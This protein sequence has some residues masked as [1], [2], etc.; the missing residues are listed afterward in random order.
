[1]ACIILHNM[2]LDDER[3]IYQNYKDTTKFEHDNT[4]YIAESSSQPRN[5]TYQVRADRYNNLTLKQYMHRR[6]E[7]WDRQVHNAL[8]RDLVEHVWENCQGWYD[9]A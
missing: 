3:D 6:E 8:Q 1:M 4:Q 2:I 9:E 7:T 5:T